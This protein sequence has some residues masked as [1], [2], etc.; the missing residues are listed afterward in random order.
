MKAIVFKD[1]ATWTYEE[2]SVPEIKK[3]NDVLVEVEAASICGTDVLVL[4]NPPGFIGTKGS[5][6]GHECV[7]TVREIGDGVEGLK[8]G[9][10]VVLVP[11]IPCGYCES[12]RQGKAN[13]CE[14]EKVM[15]VTCD[16]VFAKY[17]VAP[18]VALTKIPDDMDKDLAI[19]AEPVKCV[20]G[21]MDWV[22]VLPGETV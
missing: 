6:L 8:V 4:G 9:D 14:N 1:L 15:G 19:F 18:E 21:A 10:R 11:N 20:M 17:F 2:R 5:I 13:M 12:C 7:G 3:V 16:G 22:R